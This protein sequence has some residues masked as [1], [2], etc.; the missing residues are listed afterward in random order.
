MSDL[1]EKWF[2]D[3]WEYSVVVGVV[4]GFL[5]VVF[6]L[7]LDVPAVALAICDYVIEKKKGR[8][9]NVGIITYLNRYTCFRLLPKLQLQETPCQSACNMQPSDL[10]QAPLC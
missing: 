2:D 1:V 8:K 10:C 3:W 4:L 9:R 5:L 6:C 7:S